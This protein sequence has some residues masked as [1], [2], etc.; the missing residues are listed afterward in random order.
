MPKIT[1]EDIIKEKLD[2]IG[3]DLENI[4]EFIKKPINI[5]YR[6]LKAYE[7]NGY[8]VYRYIPISKIQILLTP[9]NRMNTIKEKYS[10]ASN[11][12]SYVVPEKEEDILRH[13]T[14]LKMLKEVKIEEIEEVQ[15]EQ[16]KLSKQMPFKVKFEENYLWQ[17]YYSDLQDIYFMLV[18]TNDLEYAT[19]FYLLKKQ[20]EYSKTKKDEMIFVPICYENYSNKYLKNLEISDIE[21]YLWFFTKNWPNIYEVSD[22]KEN[23]SIQIIGETFVYKGISSTY[24]IKLE[25][26]EDAVK[27]YKLLKAL[28]I[29]STELPHYYNFIVK[30]DRYGCLEFRYN[31]KKITYDNMLLMLNKEYDKAKDEIIKLENDKVQMEEELEKLKIISKSKDEEYLS[32]ER[33]I[34]TYLECRKTFFGRVKYFFKAKKM[35]KNI[36]EEKNEK[37]Q[38]NIEIK[39]ETP[40]IDFI[41]K[42]YYTI[43]DIIKIYKELDELKG[44]VKN[45]TLDTNA[46]KNKIESME[47]KIN[48]ANLYIQEIDKHE[49]SIFEFWKFANKDEKLMLNQAT[50]ESTTSNKKIQKVYNYEEDLEEIGTL[51]DK[52]QRSI[53][54]KQD[55]DSIFIATTEILKD[56]NNID[57][58]DVLKKSLEKLEDE[59]QT[60]RILFDTDKPDIFGDIQ[61]DSTKI[62]ILGN[63]KHRENLRDKLKI[64]DINSNTTLEEYKDKLIQILDNI[65]NSLDKCKGLPIIPIYI[66]SSDENN[67]QGLKTFDINPEK[68]I[69]EYEDNSQIDLYKINIDEN[70]KVI[71]FSNSIYYNNYNKTLP[72]GMNVETKGLINL[73][74]YELKQVCKDDFRINIEVDEFKFSTKK[75]NLYEYDLTEKTK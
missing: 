64:L 35:K 61:E 25:S 34:A 44:K 48:N 29:L 1:N 47:T 55:L 65:N 3:L 6:P 33:Q 53:Y 39:K 46:L 4:P 14:F 32:K 62:K 15:E 41:K 13:T 21:K 67:L 73:D 51:V 9:A 40:K 5:E 74:N 27:F 7:E 43:E 28:F 68:A 66:A 58:A 11:L 52:Q 56:L 37:E 19:F 69:E 8:K 20:I 38:K 50:D 71:Y 75:I 49:K 63:K 57:D 60:K 36:K 10:K 16:K 12:V 17:I 54:T 18:P 31:S 23:L 26:K 22:K 30:I 42:E 45:L 70:T 72:L 24:K 59:L 2:Y